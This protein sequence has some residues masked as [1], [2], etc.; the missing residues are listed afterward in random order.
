M[1]SKFSTIASVDK[2]VSLRQLEEMLKDQ[3]ELNKV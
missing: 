1:E 2:M 3:K